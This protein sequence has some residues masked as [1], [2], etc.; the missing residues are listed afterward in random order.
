MFV[1][2][3]FSL[4]LNNRL[5]ALRVKL[6]EPVIAPGTVIN[7]ELFTLIVPSPVKVIPRFALSEKLAPL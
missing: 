3:S 1:P 5:L 6:P 7:P 4:E 2:V